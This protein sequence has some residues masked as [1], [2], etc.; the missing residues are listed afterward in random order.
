MYVSFFPPQV[1]STEIH[2]H[3]NV[4]ACVSPHLMELFSSDVVS[5]VP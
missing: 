2:A 1:G 5:I 3:R 4:L